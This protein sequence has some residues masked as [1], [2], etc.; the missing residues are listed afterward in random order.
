MD[1]TTALSEAKKAEATNAVANAE[2]ARQRSQEP[3]TKKI[4]GDVLTEFF[5]SQT[6]EERFI[7]TQKIPFICRDIKQIKEDLRKI[8]E[9][10]DENYVTQTE[11]WPVKTVVYGV[12]GIMLVGVVTGLVLLVVKTNI[13]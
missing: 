1:E 10:M 5:G 4:M 2:E 6:E 12:V 9:N 13:T 7:S 3:L 8:V 11:Y